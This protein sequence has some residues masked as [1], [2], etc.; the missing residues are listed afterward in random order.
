M[1]VVAQRLRRFDGA[2]YH[3]VVAAAFVVLLGMFGGASRADEFQQVIVAAAALAAI[4]AALWPLEFTAL[5]DAR[6]LIVGLALVYL[7]LLVQFVPLPPGVWT[8]LPGHEPYAAVAQA[9]GSGAWRPLTLAP[10]LT[11]NALSGLLPATALGLLGLMLDFR[12]RIR[13]GY[14]IAGLACVSAL[15]ALV[16]LAVGGNTL[17]LFRTSSA[18]S[19]VGLFANRNH[20]AALMAVSLPLLA[21]LATARLREGAR[22]A[23]VLATVAGTM[24]LLLIAIAAS[25]SRMGL[26]LGAVGLAAALSIYLS[27][28]DRT[29]FDGPRRPA[30]WAAGAAAALAAIVPIA[31]LIARSGVVERLASRD[32][33]EQTRV[34]ALSPMLAAARAFMPFGSGFGTFEP[35][36]QRFEPA[37]LL[38]T[39]YLNQA[40]NEPVQLALEGGVAALA[41]LALFLLWWVRASIRA[42]RPRDSA[43]R[44]A[45]GIAAASGTL[46]LMVSSLVD[47]PLRTP[48]LSGLFAL[49]CAEL[50]R[51]THRRPQAP[52][53]IAEPA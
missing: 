43:P 44:R 47:Y 12:G 24:A 10:E 13:L 36:Y 23:R 11:L 39:I 4:G 31:L 22:P 9:V 46:I 52:R 29:A 28:S 35:V 38:S 25:G 50:A 18:D 21:A 41:L 49:M 17:H 53:Q 42:V 16:Q 3:F 34:A 8:R 14:W 45:M 40:H 30:L 2:R 6:G 27:C 48:L 51:S 19:A 15:L 5:R 1:P 26:V 37:A 20:Q 32:A 7:V 33:I